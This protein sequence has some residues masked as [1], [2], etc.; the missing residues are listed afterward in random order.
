[1]NFTERCIIINSTC[2]A[3]GIFTNHV[4]NQG[5]TFLT[6]LVP[7]NEFFTKTWKSSELLKHA[8]S[9]ISV[10]ILTITTQLNLYYTIT[11]PCSSLPFLQ[12]FDKT[13]KSLILFLLQSKA[14]CFLPKKG[15][16]KQAEYKIQK[17]ACVYIKTMW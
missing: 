10:Q 9:D 1:M 3:V 17:L 4:L 5:M 8:F 11:V 7:K 13:N 6:F 16:L 12:K 15:N 2:C 14:F